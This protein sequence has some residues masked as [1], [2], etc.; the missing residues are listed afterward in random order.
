MRDRERERETERE[1]ER[2]REREKKQTSFRSA[3]EDHWPP[4]TIQA[5][6]KKSAP[7]FQVRERRDSPYQNSTVTEI[8]ATCEGMMRRNLE[9]GGERTREKESERVKW[10]GK[11]KEKKNSTSTSSS[12]HTAAAARERNQTTETLFPL[13]SCV[14]VFEFF[15]ILQRK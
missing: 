2:E 3:A 6:G 7:L 13:F 15:V 1:R 12:S 9:R 14:F 11:L 5:R 4:R 10:K 8:I